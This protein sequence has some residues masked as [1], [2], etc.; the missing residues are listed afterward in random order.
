MRLLCIGIAFAFFFSS[1]SK[2]TKKEI[3][4][5]EQLS[6]F[7]DTVYVD[8]GDEILYLQDKLFLSDLSADKSYLINFNRKDVI[9]ERINLDELKLEKL[10]PFEKEGPNGTPAYFSRFSLNHE[11]QLLIWSYQFYSIFDQNAKKVKDLELEKIAADYLAGSDFYPSML[12]EDPKQPDRL[13]GVFISWKDRT[14][15]ILDFDLN[16]KKFKKTDL[17]EMDKLQEYNTDIVM[18]GQA[19]GS[20]GVAVHTI[21]KNGNI[22]LTNNSFNEAVI[23]D[24][25]KDSTYVKS[26][27]TPLLGS[28]K[29][30]TPP[31]QVEY[32]SG[33]REEVVRE[34]MKEFNYG[35]LVWDEAQNRF[36]RFSIKQQFGEDKDEYDQYIATGTD[37]YLNIFDENLNIL[38]ESLVPQLDA[39]PK[40]HFV[41]DGKIWIFENIDD[42]M[43]FVQLTIE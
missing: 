21:A 15:F 39:P 4:F 24:T 6:F 37:V 38:A 23:Y 40:K 41:K 26:W 22:I 10:I 19:M 28:R 42:E 5:P 32:S 11:E 3:E 34:S 9:A 7:L 12:F 36:Y 13:L 17:P 20:Y 29:N 33:Q 1:C 31:K 25:N 16:R 35:N 14:Y 18:D 43:A 30:Y 2:N 27:D 8:P